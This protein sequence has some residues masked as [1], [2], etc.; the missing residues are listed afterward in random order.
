MK[1]FKRALLKGTFNPLHEGHEY[2]IQVAKNFSEKTDIY[3]GAK[4]RPNLLPRNIR[5]NAIRKNIQ[6][7]NWEKY[8]NII[9]AGRYI[10]INPQEYSLFI[11]GSD[12]LNILSIDISK[13][14][15][16][17]KQMYKDYYLAFPNI[18]IANR[19]EMPLKEKSREKLTGH[20]NII[21][22]PGH[23]D[24]SATKIRQAYKE[25][26]DISTMVSKATWDAIKDHIHIF[27]N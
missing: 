15:K 23:T 25:G 12:L 4:Q 9:E 22:H 13:R 27:K 7:N 3:V 11:T 26:K 20:T 19:K 2:L 21:Y 10:D 16:K 17:I 6:H 14:N 18:L 24:M 8:F 1:K 5:A